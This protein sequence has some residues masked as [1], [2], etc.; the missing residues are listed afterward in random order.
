MN[1]DSAALPSE[2]A[3]PPPPTKT[4]SVSFSKPSLPR[5]PS[6]WPLL[7]LAVVPALI[8]GVLVFVL[9]DGGSSGGGSGAA[10]IVDGFIQLSQSGDGSEVLSYEGKLPPDFPKDLPQY[11]GAKTVVSFAMHSDQG[12]TFFAVLST[13]DSPEKVLDYYHG[14]LDAD[15]W[16]VEIARTSEEF[17]GVRFSRPDNADVQGDISVRRSD[18]DKRTAIFV[19]YQD[20]SS[21]GRNLPP[22]KDF[23]PGASHDLPTGF[24]ND[25]PIY[26]GKNPTTVTET[27]FQRGAGGTNFVV[28]FVTRDSQDDVVDFYK[29]EFQKLGWQVSDSTQ[30]TRGFQVQIE[31]ND[32]SRQ[33]IQGT[34]NADALEQDSRYTKVDLLVQVSASRGRGN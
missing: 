9:K 17:S 27:Y 7:A 3:G 18:L 1:E 28:T 22:S 33:Q 4:R 29:R 5:L 30:P 32:G 13:G 2:P 8:V 26:R 14:K 15:P 16:Q 20:V 11:R 25:V 12:T 19:S 21:T 24:P 6:W 34:L 23:E 10:A 31:F